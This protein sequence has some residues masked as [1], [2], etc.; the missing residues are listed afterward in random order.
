MNGVVQ[1]AEESGVAT[2]KG[3]RLNREEFLKWACVHIGIVEDEIRPV[4]DLFL[5]KG[6][7]KASARSP[8]EVIFKP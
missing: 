1:Y 2:F 3:K 5:K 8:D 4:L 7:L 6:I